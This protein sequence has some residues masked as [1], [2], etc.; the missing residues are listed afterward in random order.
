MN[1]LNKFGY[2]FYN[3]SPFD[4]GELKKFYDPNFF[5]NE[6][7]KIFK[8]FFNLSALGVLINRIKLETPDKSNFRILDTLK[9]IIREPSKNP[10][11]VYAHF[12]LPHD[13]FYFNS[14]GERIPEK[15]RRGVKAKKNKKNY[16]E[17]LIFTNSVIEDIV[18][19]ILKK[20]KNKPIIVASNNNVK[21]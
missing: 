3:L 13:P 1:I 9:K 18:Q 14:K 6:P 8:Y 19:S 12:M 7:D 21:T 5:P 2:N 16:L 15:E 20:S 11:F 17:Q 10:K 4:F